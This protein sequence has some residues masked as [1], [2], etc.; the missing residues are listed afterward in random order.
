VLS[1]EGLHPAV[2]RSR[3]GFALEVPAD[4]SERAAAALAAY[5]RENPPPPP[6]PE[7]PPPSFDLAAGLAT[8]ALLLACFAVTGPRDYAVRWFERGS[9]DAEL[10]LHGEPWRALTALALHADLAHLVGNAI[11]GTIFV[12]AVCGALGIGLGGALVLASGGLGNLVN[13]LAHGS[14]YSSVGASTAIFGAVGILAAQGVARLRRRGIGGRRALAP[15]AAGL[16]LLAML[17]TGGRADLWGHLFGLLAGAVLG[18]A[19]T[20]VFPRPPGLAAQWLLGGAAAAIFLACWY[21]AL[22]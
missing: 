5:D 15:V 21:A 10:I 9:A 19:G 1:S 18:L 20:R 22:R 7:E 17:G 11:A 3:G 4:E 13:A 6:D 2:S 14:Q 16:G 8:A 12:G